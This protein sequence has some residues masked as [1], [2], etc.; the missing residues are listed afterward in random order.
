M[1]TA[2]IIFAFVTHASICGCGEKCGLRAFYLVREMRA[3][4][5]VYLFLI[6]L[7]VIFIINYSAYMFQ[8]LEL[9]IVQ[10]GV[11]L[12]S[13]CGSSG[14]CCPISSTRYA[15]CSSYDAVCC[16]DHRFCCPRDT[17]VCDV[18][19]RRCLGEYSTVDQKGSRNLLFANLSY[20]K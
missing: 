11:C 9:N 7:S 1:L 5:I 2:S 18:E 14:T 17:P 13:S 16:S 3:Q 20:T 10:G 19:N 15:C 12:P 6:I 8:L 4:R